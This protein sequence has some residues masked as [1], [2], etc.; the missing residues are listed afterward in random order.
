[1]LLAAA[2]ALLAGLGGVG[3]PAAPFA[4]AA[5]ALAGLGASCV[6]PNVITLVGAAYVEA[7]GAA[8]SNAAGGGAFGSLVFP[9]L[10]SAIS[11]AWGVRAG[12]VFYALMAVVSLVV[13]TALARAI[14]TG[15][16]RKGLEAREDRRGK[17]AGI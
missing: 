2:I 4:L 9:F 14:T 7:P 8:I 16:M 12:F 1:V 3:L 5:V 6:Y 13:C 15:K 10:M 11:T 17:E